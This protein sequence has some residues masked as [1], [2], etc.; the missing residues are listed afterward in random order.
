MARQ[1]K[2]AGRLIQSVKD[3]HGV[4]R[5]PVPLLWADIATD[6]VV[7]ATIHID[8]L[9]L[10][11]RLAPSFSISENLFISLRRNRFVAS[12]G[13]VQ[14]VKS[15]MDGSAV[16]TGAEGSESIPLLGE[17]PPRT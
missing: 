14:A 13:R 6:T 17:P 10:E 11:H 8:F 5:Q 3:G 1:E 2:I 9:V 15:A 12:Q 7:T 4:K 16:M